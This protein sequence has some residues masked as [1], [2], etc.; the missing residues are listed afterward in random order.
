MTFPE[1]G[2]PSYTNIH[3]WRT[4]GKNLWNRLPG[5]KQTYRRANDSYICSFVLSAQCSFLHLISRTDHST[6]YCGQ[7]INRISA[8]GLVVKGQDDLPLL[9]LIL[10]SVCLS[11]A[12][13]AA[14]S[15][16]A[17]SVVSSAWGHLY[18]APH[19]TTLARHSLR[20]HIETI[21]GFVF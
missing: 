10:L 12:W 4:I 8:W 7:K 2:L 14:A 17:S 21:V 13:D 3:T 15:W 9:L 5:R 19:Q 6:N 1:A 18:T 20:R 11:L 16:S